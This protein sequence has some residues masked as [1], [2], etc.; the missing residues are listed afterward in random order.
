MSLFFGIEIYLTRE[1]Q[2]IALYKKLML[3]AVK[4]SELMDCSILDLLQD[5]T[6]LLLALEVIAIELFA[7][8]ATLIFE[9]VFPEI[10]TK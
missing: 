6:S 4:T 3:P 2:V 7:I 8:F 1:I 5:V 9:M 10:E